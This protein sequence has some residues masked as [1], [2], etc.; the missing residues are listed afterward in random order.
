VS[1][2]RRTL[3]VALAVAGWIGALALA[4]WIVQLRY[5]W[6]DPAVVAA[7]SGMYAF[8]D[9][10]MEVTVAAVLS[11]PATWMLFRAVRDLD[12][13]WRLASWA[14][15][16]WAAC[17]PTSVAIRVLV[18][19]AARAAGGPPVPGRPELSVAAVAD[20]LAVLRLLASP[21]SLPG[22]ALAWW[23]CVHEPSTRRLRWAVWLELAGT[24]AGALWLVWALSRARS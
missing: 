16:A 5:L 2:A 6:E 21:A 10:I 7:S 24:V 1:R 23:A 17:A 18:A 19:V 8:G 11:I 4:H 22:L 13:F 15:L 20:V 3:F 12:G 9:A 14:G